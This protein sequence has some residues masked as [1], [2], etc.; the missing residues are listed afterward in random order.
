LFFVVD[1]VCC[2][3]GV[4]ERVTSQVFSGGQGKAFPVG[5]GS[6]SSAIL[7]GGIGDMEGVGVILLS[8]LHSRTNLPE[9]LASSTNYGACFDDGLS[10]G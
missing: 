9:K 3:F 10:C 1:C 6:V 4:T 7:H 8:S 5:H 2:A